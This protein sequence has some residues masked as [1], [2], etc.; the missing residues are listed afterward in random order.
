M[1]LLIFMLL[2]F[3]QICFCTK[4]QTVLIAAS[5]NVLK[6]QQKNEQQEDMCPQAAITQAPARAGANGDWTRAPLVSA[7]GDVNQGHLNT[8]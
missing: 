4:Y 1:V 7:S 2:Q 6:H 8:G 5:I 3:S